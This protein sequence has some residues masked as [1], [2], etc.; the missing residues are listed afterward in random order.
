[1]EVHTNVAEDVEIDE[2]TEFAEFAERMMHCLIH[3][4]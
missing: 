1:M 4:G 2:D 3:Q